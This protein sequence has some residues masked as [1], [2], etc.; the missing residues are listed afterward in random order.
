MNNIQTKVGVDDACAPAPEDSANHQGTDVSPDE[1][2]HSPFFLIV[3][4]Q[5]YSPHLEEQ[6]A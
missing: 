3:L 4:S 2:E 1:P 6:T 5:L